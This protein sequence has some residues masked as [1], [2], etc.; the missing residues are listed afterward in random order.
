MA[1]QQDGA[2]PGEET[3][4]TVVST[5]AFPGLYQ[6]VLRQIFGQCGVGTQ[7]KCLPEEPR[8]VRAAQLAEGVGV[9]RLR[10]LE[11]A[12]RECLIRF[13]ED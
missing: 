7:R 6:R 12:G 13:Q 4:A 3:A 2:Q 8:F 10:S 5:K 1:I 9:T 11:Q